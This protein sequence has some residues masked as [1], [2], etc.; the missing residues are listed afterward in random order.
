MSCLDSLRPPEGSGPPPFAVPVSRR[1]LL[2]AGVAGAGLALLPSGARAKTSARLAKSSMGAKASL[3][4]G[5]MDFVSADPLPAD[6]TV[7]VPLGSSGGPD[8]FKRFATSI[9][10]WVRGAVYVVDFGVGMSRQFRNA[11]ALP[12][13]G[14]RAGFVSHFHSDHIG[15]IYNFFTYNYYWLSKG[16]KLFGPP[17]AA[18]NGGGGFAVPGLPDVPGAPVYGSNPTRGFI[19]FMHSWQE[20]PF[21]YDNNL[22]YRDEGMPNLFDNPSG[23]HLELAEV[24]LPAGASATNN[25][26]S[27]DP[28][29]VYEDDL[30]KV[31]AILVNHPP[32]FP[33]YAYRFDT[34]DGSIVLSG[35]TTECDNLIKLAKDADILM[36]EAILVDYL[37]WL[38]GLGVPP[39]LIKHILRSHTADKSGAIAGE[40]RVGVGEVANRAN[41]KHLVLYHTVRSEYNVDGRVFQIPNDVLARNAQAEFVGPVTVADDLVRIPVNPDCRKHPGRRA[42]AATHERPRFAMPRSS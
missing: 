19:D 23:V 37:E 42:R 20:G 35:D 27:M 21:A 30:V 5:F 38:L 31:T 26:P 32:M 24:P 16:V 29:E 10:I 8:A 7:I 25:A 12:F 41:A 34:P 18:S 36:H 28:V 22:R 33:V 11:V 1:S 13:G 3:A 17:S 4:N 40:T 15:D 39:A 2:A 9:A 6:G 14:L